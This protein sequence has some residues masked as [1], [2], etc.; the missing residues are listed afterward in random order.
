[1]WFDA[2]IDAEMQRT[3]KRP[4][5]RG[6][7]APGEAL[8]F[9]VTL[10]IG[11]VVVLGLTVNWPAG[12]C[13]PFTIG[14][15]PLRLHH[16]AQAPHAAEHRD[17]RRGRGAFP[18]MI[19]WAAVTGQCRTREHR[20]VLII[21]MWTPPHFWALALYRR[22]TMSASAC[23]CCPWWPA[24]D[25]TRRQI[26]IYSMAAGAG[27]HCCRRDLGIGGIAY[28]AAAV[29]GVCVPGSMPGRSSAHREGPMPPTG[30]ARSCSS[31]SILYLFAAV[32]DP[33]RTGAWPVPCSPV[34]WGLV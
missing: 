23:R 25:E 22:G 18:P 31:F 33:H 16:V 4:I 14:F 29:L 1:M 2:D 11:S 27:H 21:F 7:I 15:L 6:R 20:A 10:A 24:L 28:L 12:R 9:G 8:G 5:P 26:W 17:R 13:W 3:A 30:A 34:Q 19:G 32:R